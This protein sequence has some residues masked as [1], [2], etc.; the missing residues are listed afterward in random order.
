MRRLLTFLAALALGSEAVAQPAPPVP[1]AGAEETIVV[2]GRR[3]GGLLLSVDFQRVARQCAECKRVLGEIA[4][5]SA[6]YQVKKREIIRDRNTMV[7]SIQAHT[8]G[9]GRRLPAGAIPDGADFLDPFAGQPQN[10]QAARLMARIPDHLRK[11]QAELGAM[12]ADVNALVA[13]FLAQLEPEILKAAEDERV[14]RGASGV[15][16]LKRRASRPRAVDVTDAIIRR[17]DGRRLTIVLPQAEAPATV[18]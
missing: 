16:R 5:L 10:S 8:R 6:P 11:D 17:I 13:A 14:E 12:R 15:I 7:E 9:G 4:K 3:D 1:Q 18:R 2:T